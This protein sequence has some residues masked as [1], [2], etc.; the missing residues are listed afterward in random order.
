MKRWSWITGIVFLALA[1]TAGSW[2]IYG[3]GIGR[4]DEPSSFVPLGKLMAQGRLEPAGEVIDIGAVM[5]DRLMSVAV[6]EGDPVKK[7][8]PLASLDSQELRKLEVE[9]TENQLAEA[10]SRREAELALAEARIAAGRLAVEQAGTH[11]AEIEAEALKIP[12]LERSLELATKYSRRLA[13]LAKEITSDQELDQSDFAVRKAKSEL[14]AANKILAKNKHS[15]RIALDAAQAE[16]NA[17]LAAKQVALSAVPDKSLKKKLE[18]TRAQ[19]DRSVLRSPCDGTILKVSVRP[20]ELIGPVPILQLADLE[21]MVAVAQV[22][23]SDLKR[24]SLGQKAAVSS[25]SFPPPYDEKGLE[26]KVI[27][28]GQLI[29][30]PSLKELNPLAP[31]DRRAA[32][33]RIELTGE[34][35]AQAKRFVHMQVDVEFLATQP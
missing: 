14:E 19:L 16:L 3:R 17:A 23:E 4:R 9:A 22:Y 15:S 20:G 8:A 30:Q 34:S 18:L 29:S 5:G 1:A 13:A 26:G 12:V 11:Q 27:R 31:A 28:I 32:E 2:I 33:V 25:R 6:R 35:S 10:E 21:R 7:G 24:I